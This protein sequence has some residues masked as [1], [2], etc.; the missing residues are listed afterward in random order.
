MSSKTFLKKIRS[1]KDTKI[2]LFDS[3][4][5]ILCLDKFN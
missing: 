4:E 5:T 2:Y 1:N 3:L